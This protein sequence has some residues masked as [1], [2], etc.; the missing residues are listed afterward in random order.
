M[1]IASAPPESKGN[2]LEPVPTNA[3]RRHPDKRL[4][5]KDRFFVQEEASEVA[6]GGLDLV[7]RDQVTPR[8]YL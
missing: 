1:N 3:I 7:G 8:R 5:V 2:F 6:S 4:Y